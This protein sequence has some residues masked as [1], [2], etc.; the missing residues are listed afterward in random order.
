MDLFWAVFDAGTALR[1]KKFLAWLA[2]RDETRIIVVAHRNVF[3][4]MLGLIL[5]NCEVV[6]YALEDGA[7]T[8]VK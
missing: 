4:E 1:C 6:E 5:G 7:L 2:E 3:E 8:A